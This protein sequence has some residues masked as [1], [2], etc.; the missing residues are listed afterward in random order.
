MVA[1]P[2]RPSLLPRQ[3]PAPGREL[4]P[5]VRDAPRHELAPLESG[6]SSRA[7]IDARAVGRREDRELKRQREHRRHGEKR[8]PLR[9]RRSRVAVFIVKVSS[10][11]VPTAAFARARRTRPRA[12]RR[13]RRRA[14]AS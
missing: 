1:Q 2:H 7:S 10:R 12:H 14:R 6:R 11:R 3:R 5:R 9:R 4:E 8:Q 13:P